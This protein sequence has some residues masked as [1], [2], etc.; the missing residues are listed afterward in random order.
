MKKKKLK[1]YLKKWSESMI[2]PR[3]PI[4]YTGPAGPIGSQGIAGRG[5]KDIAIEVDATGV[6]IGG[7]VTYTDGDTSKII[8]IKED[9]RAV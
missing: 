2:G 7:I 1:K 3:G 8:I 6:V 4:G 5:V 9:S